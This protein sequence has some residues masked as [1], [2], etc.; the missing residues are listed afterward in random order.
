M[1]RIRKY[2]FRIWIPGAII[3]ALPDPDQGGQLITDPA[4]SGSYLA[5]FELNE[6]FVVKSQMSITVND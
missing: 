5:I 2:F 6:K 4:R 3:P 1:L